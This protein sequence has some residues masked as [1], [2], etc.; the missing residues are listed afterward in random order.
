MNNTDYEGYYKSIM[1]SRLNCMFERRI[2]DKKT[3]EKELE[4]IRLNTIADIEFN[5][6]INHWELSK[7]LEEEFNIEYETSDMVRKD[8]IDCPICFETRWGVRL[9]NCQHYICSVCY[10]NIYKGFIS[11]KFKQE[12]PEPIE[13]EAPPNRQIPEYPYSESELI[14]IFNN[15]R[16]QTEFELWFINS[17]EDLYNSIKKNS[18]YVD[19]LD[20][21]IREWFQNNEKIINYEKSI[22]S[23]KDSKK[24]YDKL[25]SNYHEEYNKYKKEL[26]EYN[27]LLEYEKEYN[28]KQSCPLCRK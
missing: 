8:S 21:V 9:P 5:W 6:L 7:E 23:Y 20:D 12:H 19:D 3:Y 26:E 24:E 13:P 22:K 18:E 25:W 11:E 1:Y 17:N 27:Q 4:C 2:I 28:T 10:Y 16:I 14:L 15:F